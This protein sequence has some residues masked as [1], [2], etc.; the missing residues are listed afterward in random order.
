MGKYPPIESLEVGWEYDAE[1]Y[2][3][4]R[5]YARMKNG[6][7]SYV[8]KVKEVLAR[9]MTGKMDLAGPLNYISQG[10]LS[11]ILHK[12]INENMPVKVGLFLGSEKIV[13]RAEVKQVVDV[14]GKFHI[15]MQFV[16]LD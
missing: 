7:I 12:R 1:G 10:G 9:A 6:E 8:L 5:S 13:S 3:G 14:D 11:V 2:Q 16:N 4:R 15:G